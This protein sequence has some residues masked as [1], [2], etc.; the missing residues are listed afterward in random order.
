[1]VDPLVQ[2]DVFFSGFHKFLVIFFGVNQPFIFQGVPL[3]NGRRV[4]PFFTNPPFGKVVKIIIFPP[5]S[6]EKQRWK[7]WDHLCRHHVFIAGLS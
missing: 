7:S 3:K 2:N 1:M 4:C 5:V 6:F